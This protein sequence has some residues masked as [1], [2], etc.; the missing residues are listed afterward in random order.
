M[1]WRKLRQ[2][3]SP[4]TIPVTSQSPKQREQSTADSATEEKQAT[5]KTD[6]GE[7]E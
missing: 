1:L 2:S 4:T 7:R 6:T 3:T 5:K